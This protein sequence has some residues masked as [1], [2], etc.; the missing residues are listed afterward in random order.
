[1]IRD[2]NNCHSGLDP[3]SEQLSFR[4]WSGIHL[5]LCFYRCM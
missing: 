4:T 3:G 1:L 5:D 2:L